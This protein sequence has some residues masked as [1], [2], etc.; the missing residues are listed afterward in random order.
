VKVIVY[1]NPYKISYIG[2]SGRRTSYFD[3]GYEGK[4]SDTILS[5]LDRRIHFINLPDS[6]TIRIYTL[7]GDLVRTLEH[8]DENLSGYPSKI[9]WDL[10]SRNTQAVASGI[11]IYRIDSRLGSQVGK[12]VIIK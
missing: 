12:I 10:V 2:P 5:E 6:A 8:P 7:D 1:P 9:S 3:Q 4:V 11:Y